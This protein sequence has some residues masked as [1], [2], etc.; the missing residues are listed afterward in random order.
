MNTLT[1]DIHDIARCLM[2]YRADSMEQFELKGCH[3]N[4]ILTLCEEPG[5]SQEQLAKRL[6]ANKSNITRQIAVLEEKGYVRRENDPSDKR[7]LHVYP[8]EKAREL[9]PLI[10]SNQKKW[11]AFVTEGLSGEELA[12]ARR[13]LQKMKEQA[14]VFMERENEWKN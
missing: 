4:Y 9:L 13:I 1:R 2:R 6:Y 7:L 10:Q 5:I 14:V 8:T 12:Q 3:A 11:D